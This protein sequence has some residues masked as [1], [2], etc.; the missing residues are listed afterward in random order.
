MQVAAAIRRKATC[1]N[2]DP[3]ARRNTDSCAD[4]LLAKK[5]CLSY[6]HA[7][8]AGWPIATGI[9]EGACRHLVKDRLDLTGTRWGLQGAEAIVKLRALRSND[10]WDSYWKFHLNHERHRTHETR[11]AD[12]APPTAA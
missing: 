1:L 6:P 10:D 8:A 5:D 9:I 2:L 7:L 12:H 3:Q 4:Y 11:Y